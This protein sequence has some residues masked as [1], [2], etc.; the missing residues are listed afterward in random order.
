M[1]LTPP[2]AHLSITFS[3]QGVKYWS[4]TVDVGFNQGLEDE[5]SVLPQFT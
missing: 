1:V 3:N 4:A 2:F 5:Y